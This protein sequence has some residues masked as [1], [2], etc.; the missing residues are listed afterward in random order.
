MSRDVEVDDMTSIVTENNRREEDAERRRQSGEELDRD[1]VA[2]M[3][4]QEG[5]LR[6]RRRFATTDHVLA[7][8][9]PATS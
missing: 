7:T 3:V 4:V 1:A 5:L 9:A 6:L 2:D 8:V